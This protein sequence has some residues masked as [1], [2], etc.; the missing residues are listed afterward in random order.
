MMDY[1]LWATVAVTSGNKVTRLRTA[2]EVAEGYG[3]KF[4][5]S[6]YSR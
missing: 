4:I 1:K 5:G 6:G 2:A 3:L